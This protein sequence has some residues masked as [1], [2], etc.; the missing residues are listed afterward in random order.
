MY[1]PIKGIKT[2]GFAGTR[3]LS[4]ECLGEIARTLLFPL[5]AAVITDVAPCTPLPQ[6]WG[7]S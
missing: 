6:L 7:A 2:R 4:N 5:A 3:G 1:E